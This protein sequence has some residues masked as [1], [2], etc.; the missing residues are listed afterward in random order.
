M[1]HPS[2]GESNHSTIAALATP[3]GPGGIAIVRISG[4]RAWEVGRRI[5]RPSRGA[6]SPDLHPRTLRHGYVIDPQCGETVDEVLCAFFPGPGT[7]TTE[8]TV[9]IQ[10]HAGPAVAERVLDLALAA[11]CRPA[12]PGEFTLRAFLGGRIDLSQAEAVAQLVQAQSLVEARLA[13]AALRGALARELAGVRRALLHTA[14]EVEACLDFPDEVPD[15]RPPELVGRLQDQVLTPLQRLIQDRLKRRVYREGGAVVICGRPNVG[16]S[17]LFNALLGGDRAIVSPTPG[18]TRDAIEETIICQGVVM[19]LVDTAGLGTG[20][21]ELEALGMARTRDRLGLAQ[22]ALVVLDA[23][24]PP[25]AEDHQVL[26]ETA[27]RPRLIC[28]NKADLPLAWPAGDLDL[29]ADTVITTSARTGSGLDELTRALARALT[30]GQPEPQP[31]QVVVSQRQARSLQEV[32]HFTRNALRLLEQAEPPYELVSIE[33]AQALRFLAL[34]DGQDAPGQ[35][36]DTVFQ[37]FCV[38]K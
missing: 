22:L 24:C 2:P 30:G 33:L 23:S 19:R 14:A 32:L 6:L 4:P 18:T 11:G 8:D 20:R 34:V 27:S 3:P 1:K 17:S 13:L 28:L 36:I 7:Y 25:S 9:E 10:G 37:N 26:R 12:R 15:I 38:G 29:E 35:V 5:F 21:D 31:G 16:K